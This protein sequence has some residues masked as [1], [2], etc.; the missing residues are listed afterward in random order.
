MPVKDEEISVKQKKFWKFWVVFSLFILGFF[1]VLLRLFII[2]VVNAEKYRES[3]RKQHQSRIPLSAQRGDIYDRNGRM[4]A[5]T[6]QSLSVAA[7]PTLLIDRNDRNMVC[8]IL[9]KYSGISK[10]Q[11]LEK[12]RN[13]S[14]EF[15]WLVRGLKPLKASELDSINIKGLIKEFEPRRRYLYDY[16]CSHVIGR[17]DIDNKGV[18]GLERQWD[19]LLQGTSGYK[20]MYR[21]AMGR[22]QPSAEL[23]DIE[24]EHGKSITLTIDIDLQKIVEHEIKNAVELNK[25]NSGSVVALDPKTG[26]ILA[27][28]S[29][30]NYDPNNFDPK[31][32]PEG[33][34][35]NRIITDPFEPGSTF[36]LITAAA[37]LEE[38]IVRPDD[39]VDGMNGSVTYKGYTIRDVHGMGRITFRMAFANS[40]N[41]VFSILGSKIPT[42]EFYKYVR[43]FGFGLVSGVDLPGES[44]GRLLKPK[45]M[46][47]MAK[48]YMGHGYGI[49]V[50]TLQLASAYATVANGGVKMNPYIVKSVS[51]DKG[52]II[53]EFKPEK[54]RRV[55]S[56]KTAQTLNELLVGVVEKGTGDKARIEGM[57]IAGKTGTAQQLVNGSY[58]NDKY[59][60]SFVGYFPADNPKL[61]IA[62]IID[63]P[64]GG[65]YYGGA[66]S[67]PVFHDIVQRWINVSP[68]IMLNLGQQNA[69]YELKS[70]RVI[71]PDIQGLFAG[72]ASRILAN[73]KLK[74]KNV[75]GLLGIVTSQHPEPGTDTTE[76]TEIQFTV[77]S[78]SVTGFA[79]GF[80]GSPVSIPDVKGITLRRALTIL[81]GMNI[82]V[83]VNGNGKVISQSWRKSLLGEVIVTLEC[84]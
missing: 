76:F 23:P 34:M 4:L 17:T 11:L 51:D 12:F 32:I 37:A 31:N 67:A 69:P 48:R 29:Y 5:T 49:S 54:V 10:K 33:A 64:Q 20:V 77:K 13:S 8:E 50:T 36:K 73:Y 24:P 25:A 19:S 65:I 59:T 82:N 35:R 26:E 14:G 56:Q 39:I 21:D 44:S 27:M 7:D 43:D 57:P 2:Q 66:V 18:E 62:V 70:K 45:Q 84:Q 22:L 9:Q 60:S 53:R 41:V 75:T 74:P 81:H 3:A 16:V 61:V 80:T 63:N 6:F 46:T 38:G 40:S 30:P 15:V 71:V 52:N 68:D 79:K 78:S 47:P 1:V 72:D 28:A 83:R 42:D 55:I 58:N